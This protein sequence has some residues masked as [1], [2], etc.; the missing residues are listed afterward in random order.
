MN[1]DADLAAHVHP[2]SDGT[3][4]MITAAKFQMYFGLR[5]SVRGLLSDTNGVLS[6]IRNQI[7]FRASLLLSLGAIVVALVAA[8]LSLVA[9]VLPAY[10]TANLTA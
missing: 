6:S 5:D 9:G 4:A 2:P 1:L 3:T 10:L 8:V 7:D